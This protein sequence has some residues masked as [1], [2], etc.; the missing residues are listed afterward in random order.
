MA[1]WGRW[2]ARG[3]LVLLVAPAAATLRLFVWPSTQ[4]PV[5]ADAVIVLAGDQGER[6]A[7]AKRLVESGASKTLVLDGSE[8]AWLRD[9]SCGATQGFEVVCL[10]P[11]PDSTRTEAR[12]ASELAKKRRWKTVAVV[13]TKFHVTRAGLL[14][15]RCLAGRVQ[16]V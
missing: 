10:S 4:H 6:I 11:K 1:R 8:R 9:T 12:A 7:T 16:M 2:A 3:A 5:R 15:R 13:T 14:F